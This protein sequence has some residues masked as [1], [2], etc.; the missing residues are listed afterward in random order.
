[1]DC[2]GP[3]DITSKNEITKE[4]QTE[5]LDLL[6]I[7]DACLGWVKLIMMKIKMAKYTAHLFDIYWLYQYPQPKQVIYNNGSELIGFEFQELHESYG[8]GPRPTTVNNLQANSVIERLHLTLGNQIC[9]TTFKGHNFSK[10]STS[11][12]KPVPILPKAL[13]QGA[14]PTCLLNSPFEW[15]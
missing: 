9:C 3:W 8:I 6:T 5:K 4:L 13:Y 15:T 1:M 10:K 12:Y 2:T 7:L 11:L 14:I